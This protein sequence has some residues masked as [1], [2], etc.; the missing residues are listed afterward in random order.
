M[1]G[2]GISTYG[3]RPCSKLAIEQI[4]KFTPNAKIVAVNQYGIAQSKN[5]CLAL[6]DDCEHIFLFDDDTYPLINGWHLPYT[7]SSIKHLSYT[8]NRKVLGFHNQ[9]TIYEKP[10]GCML[11][12]HRDCIE[13]VGGFDIEYKLYGGEHEDFSRRVY[14]A[15]LT[16]FPYMDLITSSCLIHSMDE[17][18]QVVSSVPGVDRA[19]VLQSNMK[20]VSDQVNS[21]EFKS[22]K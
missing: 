16:P 9:C 8:F 13:A 21:K 20:R 10:S 4:R 3:N 2:V 14:N 19:K 1:I 6:L 12:I 15:G 18:K 5:M 7:E 22:Y 11:Y 17:H